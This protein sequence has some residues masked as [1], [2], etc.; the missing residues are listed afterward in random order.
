MVHMPLTWRPSDEIETDLEAVAIATGLSKADILA[1]SF[2]AWMK[3]PKN[4]DPAQLDRAR[5]VLAA[6][7][8]RSTR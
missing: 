7:K 1:A 8:G 6:R 4:V 3:N 2:L 5:V